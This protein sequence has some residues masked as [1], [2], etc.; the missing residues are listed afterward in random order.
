M[1]FGYNYGESITTSRPDL[2]LDTF[3][4]LLPALGL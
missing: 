4:E 3:G 2:T 1:T